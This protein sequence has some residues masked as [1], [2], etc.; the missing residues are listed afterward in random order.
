MSLRYTSKWLH[1]PQASRFQLKGIS[2]S[3]RYARISKR[4]GKYYM[5]LRSRYGKTNMY[6]RV[7]N[8]HEKKYQTIKTIL[9]ISPDG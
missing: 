2:I 8:H 1:V 9:V 3:S 4:R 6:M 5:K 7:Y